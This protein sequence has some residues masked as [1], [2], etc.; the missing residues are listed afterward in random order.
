[1]C[2]RKERYRYH[3]LVRIIYT[4]L[5]QVNGIYIL[6]SGT[7]FRQFSKITLDFKEKPVSVEIDCV[8]VTR[9]YEPDV[10]L[11]SVL[12]KYTGVFIST[13]PGLVK[14]NPNTMQELLTGR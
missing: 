14:N 2:M 11:D 10:E 1:M 5:V 3:I 13:E 7:D 6:K 4:C 12:E 9:D 8:D